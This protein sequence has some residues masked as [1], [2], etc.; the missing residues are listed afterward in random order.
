MLLFNSFAVGNNWLNLYQPNTTY[1]I[2]DTFSKTFGGHSLSFGGELKYYRLNAR[3]ECG[4]NGYFQF[5]GNET[6]SDVSDYFVGAPNGF[7]QC[8]VQLL[9]NRTRYLGLFATDSWKVS[10]K[11]DPQLW[12]PV[13]IARPWSDVYSRLTTPVPGVQSVKF[14]DSP[15]GNL[16]PGDPGVP[17]TIS[18][19]RYNNF[20]PRI[21]LL[22]L[23]SIK[24]SGRE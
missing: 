5:N 1:G 24:C 6:G 22:G 21:G 3:N 17:T 11:P 8:S 16:V 9:D 10:S 13:D 4:P 2:A 18:P 23:C 12:P 19:T 15:T 7:V 20:G 14:P